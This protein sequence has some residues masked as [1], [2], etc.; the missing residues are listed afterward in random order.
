MHNYDM[1]SDHDFELLT[2]DLLGAEDQVRYEVFARGADQGIDL[3]HVS[4]AGPDVVQCKHMSGSTY[5]QLR[6]AVRSEAAKVANLSP[7]PNTYR[8]VTTQK[9]TLKRKTE[10]S[11]ILTPWVKR[12][13]E[14]MGIDEMEGLLIRHPNVERGHI[15]L[16]LSSAA[17]LDERLHAATWARS[18]QVLGEIRQWLPRYVDSPV[19]WEANAKLRDER[20][21]VISGPP[22]IGKTTLARML[23]ADAA[24]DGYEA[25]EISADIDE[26]FAVISDEQPQIFYYDD[27]L[28][29]TFLEDRLAKNED[30]RLTAFMRRVSV[31]KNALLVF[32]TREH[33]LQQA[34][35]WYEELGNSGLPLRRFLL[36][37]GSYSRL[38]RARIF[39][40]HIWHAGTLNQDAKDNLL[41][42][43]NFLKIIDHPNYNPR[44]IE[45]V[46]GLSYRALGA[47]ELKDYSSFALA[48]L[49][50]PELIWEYAFS[51]QLDD[52]CRILLITLATMPGQAATQDL[53]RAYGSQMT[54]RGLSASKAQF[55]SALRILDDS[56]TR[57]HEDS[58]TTFISL[59]NP[60]ID[61]Y[62]A[63]WMDARSDEALAALDGAVYFEQLTW[64]LRRVSGD[65]ST[66]IQDAID[67]A[68]DR[69]WGSP[70]PLWQHVT[71]VHDNTVHA[72]RAS[73]PL[74]S[75]LLFV[76]RLLGAG[77]PSS[78]VHFLED[79]LA[80]SAKGPSAGLYGPTESVALV[81]LLREKGISSPPGLVESIRDGLREARYAYA[82]EK[83]L[84]LR[85]LEPSYFTH[86]INRSIVSECGAWVHSE[87]NNVSDIDS[88]F[89]L[90]SI[91]SV[92]LAV[93]VEVDDGLFE[94]AAE[95]LSNRPKDLGDDSLHDRRRIVDSSETVQ[96][97]DHAIRSLFSRLSQ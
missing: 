46:T 62:I 33:I 17:Q 59:A 23:I 75:R 19:F 31:S 80:E 1:L 39:Y 78:I 43:E 44:L 63:G 60:S 79:K 58:S 55:D 65:Q 67:R 35:S 61:D 10:L 64:L 28:G 36:E 42:D 32:T 20:V 56:F 68:M 8:L 66:E 9:L 81:R 72:L 38:D 92:A 4:K 21:I 29:S 3:R 47:D 69:C 83:L 49:D 77:A 11:A 95:E 51:R 26:G 13:D 16:W 22:G 86:E 48:V 74:L 24:V 88:E 30:K 14:L 7:V 41:R 52:S 90:D 96:Q 6:S 53:F 2:A 45:Y 34:A 91:R 57:S 85:K 89:E 50:K 12:T 54:V 5:A 27:F 82:W 18:R 84:E 94:S 87:L 25:I 70:S 76:T 15:K 40:S 93:G 71:Y 37:L 73:N 97:D